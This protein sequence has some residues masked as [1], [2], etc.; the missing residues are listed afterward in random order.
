MA[1]PSA[2]FLE[3]GEER[4]EGEVDKAGEETGEE[5][6]GEDGATEGDKQKEEEAAA[7]GTALFA[8]SSCSNRTGV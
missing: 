2:E 1:A 3:E 8:C 4:V 5:A 6:E 7:A